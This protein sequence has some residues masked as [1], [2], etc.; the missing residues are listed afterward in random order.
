[1]KNESLFKVEG[2][3][4]VVYDVTKKMPWD[5]VDPQYVDT[6]HGFAVH[7]PLVSVSLRSRVAAI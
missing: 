1:M 3:E 2:V 4:R 5:M 6:V 7:L